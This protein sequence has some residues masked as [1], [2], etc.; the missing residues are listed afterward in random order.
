MEF[1]VLKQVKNTGLLQSEELHQYILKT[2]VYPQE[3]EPLKELREATESHPKSFMSGSPLAGQLISLILKLT[4]AKKTIEVGVFTGYSLLLTAL[5]IPDDGKI[6]AIDVDRDAYEIGLPFIQKAGVEH[7]INF[8]LSDAQIALDNLLQEEGNEGS[9]DFAFV[10]A[11]KPN[12]KK[13]HERLMK[14][15]KVGGMVAYDNTLWGGT[16]AMPESEV[17]EFMKP[18]REA[19]VELNKVL[20]SDPQIEIA[21]LPLGD[22]VT[23]CRRLY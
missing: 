14:L 7:K 20:A 4:N 16:V 19:V 9:F 22:G 1:R 12:Y 17:L 5:S 2:S 11:D 23:F 13:Y 8:V 6:T 18:N 15:I 21:Q 3:L 10:D